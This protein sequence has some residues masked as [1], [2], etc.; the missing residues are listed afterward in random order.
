M[1][2]AVFRP[3]LVG[4]LGPSKPPLQSAKPSCRPILDSSTP[5]SHMPISRFRN[6]VCVRPTS[7]DIKSI[8]PRTPRRV[9]SVTT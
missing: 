5:R 2:I 3:A 4:N 9:I 1:L 7:L 8:L 6:V